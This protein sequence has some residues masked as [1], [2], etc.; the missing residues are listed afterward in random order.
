MSRTVAMQCIKCILYN[1][2]G[3]PKQT[4]TIGPDPLCG[5]KSG[6]DN[7]GELPGEYFENKL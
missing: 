3:W 1:R 2:P 4:H 5:E 6:P 7:F